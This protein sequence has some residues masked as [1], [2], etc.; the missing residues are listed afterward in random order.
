MKLIYNCLIIFTVMLA[1]NDVIA[2]NKPLKVQYY[3][4]KDSIKYTKLVRDIDFNYKSTLYGK[5]T[6]IIHCESQKGDFEFVFKKKINEL[7][8]IIEYKD[9][10]VGEQYD[11]KTHRWMHQQG[12]WKHSDMKGK[13]LDT[14]IYSVHNLYAFVLIHHKG[15]MV[16]KASFQDF[17]NVVYWPEFSYNACSISDE[18]KDGRPEFYLSYMGNS[19]GLDPKPFKQIIYT[20]PANPDSQNYLKSKATVYYHAG[21]EEEEKDGHHVYTVEYDQ[22]WKRLPQKIKLKSQKIINN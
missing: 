8:R 2:Q 1:V 15:K 17:G 22:N 12:T 19:D 18:D 6:M 16:E 9:G 7:S 11:F 10:A 4:P 5:T 20:M 21:G 13:P 3:Y 14:I